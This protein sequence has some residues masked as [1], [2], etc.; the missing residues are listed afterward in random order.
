MVQPSINRLPRETLSQ[1]FEAV[2][3]ITF[4]LDPEWADIVTYKEYWFP[5]SL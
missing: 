2:L 3:P 5:L 4:D 1:I